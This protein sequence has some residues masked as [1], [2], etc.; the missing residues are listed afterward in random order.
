MFRVINQNNLKKKVIQIDY[1]MY[2]YIKEYIENNSL[3]GTHGNHSQEKHQMSTKYVFDDG[4]FI[5]KKRSKGNSLYYVTDE[6]LYTYREIERTGY[7][8]LA[9][10]FCY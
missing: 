10:S 5:E 3:K 1:S 7:Q 6:L 2:K 9:S 4:E 8:K